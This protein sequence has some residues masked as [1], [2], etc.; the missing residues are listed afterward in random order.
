MGAV[1][2]EVTVLTAAMQQESSTLCS[3]IVQVLTLWQVF[4]FTSYLWMNEVSVL[5]S[6]VQQYFH[7]LWG[8]WSVLVMVADVVAPRGTAHA[9]DSSMLSQV[10]R[11]PPTPGSV[12]RPQISPLL[13]A[14]SPCALPHGLSGQGV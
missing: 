7:S 6:V 1:I 11:H 3:G 2:S 10:L 14:G 5:A 13:P 12:S 8:L 4:L 9:L